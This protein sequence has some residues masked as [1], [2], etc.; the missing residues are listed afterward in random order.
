MDEKLYELMDWAAIEA[1]VYSEEDNPHA[2][3]GAHITNDGILIQTFIPT[4][5]RV[6][7]KVDGVKKEYP[8]EQDD[9]TGFFAVL[10]PRKTIPKYVYKVTFTTKQ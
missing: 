10:L 3:L 9:E 6:S 4:A 7:V 2:L 8:M 1:I 5:E